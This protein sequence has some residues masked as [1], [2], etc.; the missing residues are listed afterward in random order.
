MLVWVS[1]F[2]VYVCVEKLMC[3]TVSV[4]T[5][6]CVCARGV[7]IHSAHETRHDI[8]FTRSRQDFIF[9]RKLQ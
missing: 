9:L 5:L 1:E 3:V 6:I 8:G 2:G 4:F 7:M